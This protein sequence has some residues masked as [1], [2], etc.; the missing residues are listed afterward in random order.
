MAGR[1][2]SYLDNASLVEYTIRV[3]SRLTAVDRDALL[4]VGFFS[5]QAVGKPGA[6][7]FSVHC[8]TNC[9]PTVTTGIRRGPAPSRTGCGG[10]PRAAHVLVPRRAGARGARDGQP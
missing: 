7:G 6:D 8:D 3:K 5:Y 1:N 2:L 4:A 10:R 9:S